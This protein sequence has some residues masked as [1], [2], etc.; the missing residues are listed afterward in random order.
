MTF[1]SPPCA[2][3][4]SRNF[5]SAGAAGEGLP[6]LRLGIGVHRTRVREHEHARASRTDRSSDVRRTSPFQRLDRLD[7]PRWRCRSP[8]E[9]R[10]HGGEQRFGADAVALGDPDEPGRQLAGISLRFHEGAAADFHVEHERAD[11]LRRSS[12]SGSTPQISGMLSTVPVT[13]RS[14][15]S[16]RSAGAISSVCPMSAQPV[17]RNVSRISSSVSCVRNPGNRLE[18]VE[19]AARVAQTSAGHHR[20]DRAAGGGKRRD[21][22]RRLVAD[23]AGRVFVDRCAAE[24]GQIDLLAGPDHRVGEDRRF[25]DGHAAEHDRHQERRS[26]GSRPSCRRSRRRRTRGSRQ[27]KARGRPASGG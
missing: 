25:L 8:A 2:A 19:R 23:A 16:R 11:A 6:H 4:M 12:C 18:L 14:A 17:R 27:R 24:L 20:N 13:S 21:H 9:R 26:S 3:M 7:R 1:G 5:S 15:Y 22:E 10:V